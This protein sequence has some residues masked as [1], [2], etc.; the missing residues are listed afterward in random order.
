MSP[1]ALKAAHTTAGQKEDEYSSKT[2][3]TFL[4]ARSNL[5]YTEINVE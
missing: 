1:D 3:N 4:D 2:L 5:C